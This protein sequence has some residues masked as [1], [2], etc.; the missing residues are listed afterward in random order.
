MFVSCLLA[1]EPIG[2][3]PDADERTITVKYRKLALKYHP[4]KWRSDSSHGLSKE[5]AEEKFK[6]I[7]NAADHLLS[8]FDEDEEG[9]DRSDDERSCGSESSNNEEQCT[10][11]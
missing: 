11:S 2:V 7:Q 6:E 5:E 9:S 4:D 8:K 3:D 1:H 10:V